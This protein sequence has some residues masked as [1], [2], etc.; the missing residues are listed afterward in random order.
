MNYFHKTLL[1]MKNRY[2]LRRVC[3]FLFLMVSASGIRLSAAETRGDTIYNEAYNDFQILI[4]EI[5]RTSLYYSYIP[6]VDHFL[7]ALADEGIMV[8]N[9]ASKTKS[10]A[11]AKLKATL[12]DLYDQ[13]F[14]ARSEYEELYTKYLTEMNFTALEALEKNYKAQVADFDKK[15]KSARD[16]YSNTL[17]EAANNLNSSYNSLTLEVERTKADVAAAEEIY[18][19]R[20]E[21]EELLAKASEAQ[22]NSQAGRDLAAA[23][24]DAGTA[25]NA[26]SFEVDAF[27]KM[28]EALLQYIEAFTQETTAVQA[29]QVSAGLSD[30][31]SLNGVLLLRKVSLLEAADKL[32][33]GVYV[34]QGRKV[35]L[36]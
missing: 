12:D 7:D 9:E 22:K 29:P 31:Y 30:V 11:L 5:D 3:L 16:T 15:E 23:L 27:V 10:E 36:P 19:Q 25:L 4:N 26:D 13:R 21:A 6:A 8:S 20:L 18:R 35:L 34:I 28:L 14:A 33:A 17:I 32:P 24:A 1:L 2:L